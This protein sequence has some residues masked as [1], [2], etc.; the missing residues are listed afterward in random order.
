MA[1]RNSR[2]CGD[3]VPVYRGQVRSRCVLGKASIASSYGAFSSIVVLVLWVYY[4]GQIFFFGAEFTRSF[5]EC[6]GSRPLEKPVQMV[7]LAGDTQADT[8]L[9][10]EKPRIILP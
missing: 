1:R 10:Q 3:F 4:S 2:R 7:V 9:D 6:Y 8:G 5:A